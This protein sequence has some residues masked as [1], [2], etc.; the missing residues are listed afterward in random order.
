MKEFNRLA[1]HVLRIRTSHPV[2]KT[3]R[4][5]EEP[6]EERNP[7]LPGEGEQ[8]AAQEMQDRPDLL[9]RQR[10]QQREQVDDCGK[11]DLPGNFTARLLE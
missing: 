5:G 1:N 3:I 11:A 4:K 9:Q 10:P 6:A 7:P 2:V 8:E